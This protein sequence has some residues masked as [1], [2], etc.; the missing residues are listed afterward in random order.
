M[1][2]FVVV[3]SVAAATV[4][5]SAYYHAAVTDSELAQSV[6]FVHAFFA[7]AL[8]FASFPVPLH[9]QNRLFIHL[10]QFE[11]SVLFSSF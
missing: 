5:V 10:H 4:S 6:D 1:A 3:A 8:D 7:S 11:N 9:K 2:L